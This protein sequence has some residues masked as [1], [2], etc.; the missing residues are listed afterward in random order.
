[1]YGAVLGD[2]IGSTYEW[3]NVKSE[4]FDLFPSGS[5]FTDD[6]VLSVAV[7]QKILNQEMSKMSSRK[8][9]AMWYKQYYR[10]YSNAGF[11]Q[12]FSK[13]ALSNDLYVQKS[14]GNGA[15]MR[16]SA[17]GYAFESIS[18]ILK[19]VKSSCHYTHHHSEAVTGASAIA[20]AIFLARKDCDKEEIK[21]R[22]IKQ[23]SYSLDAT[24]DEIRKDYVFDSR[25]SYTVPV[26]LEAFFESDCYE[27][28]IR[29]AIS[30]G[31]DSDTIACMTGGIAQ[32]YYKKIPEHIFNTG[33]NI[34]DTGLKQVLNEFEDRYKVKR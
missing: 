12:M 4:E 11:G 6:T 19:E 7:A 32:A 30:V 9:Y 1:M 26:A 29:K 25:A 33:M 13:W 16:I 24:L 5:T 17:V 34:L 3:H 23:F 2:I 27:D 8:G 18:T 20:V 15:A 10:R 14:Y 28:A 21:E 22:I 31:G